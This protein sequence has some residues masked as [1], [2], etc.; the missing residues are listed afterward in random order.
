MKDHEFL[1]LLNLYLDHEIS[2]A[3][4]A[5]LEAEVQGNATHRGT[6]LEYCRMQKACTLLAKDF[7]D[8]PA[9][10]KVIA[11]EPRRSAWASGT[12]AVGGLA[13]AAACVALVLMKR[14]PESTDYAAPVSNQ[15]IASAPPAAPAPT[16]VVETPTEVQPA[17]VEKLPASAIAS[18]V[19]MPVRLR[20]G[21]IRPI[22][23]TTPLAQT[24]SNPDAAAMLAAL[25][26]N[27]QAQFEWMKAMQLAPMQGLSQQ[28]LRSDLGPSI[29]PASRTSTGGHPETI[30]ERTA[31]KFQK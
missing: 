10:K 22:F 15:A 21:D 30:V 31:F 13:V 25:Q 3:D 23:V 17:P 7:A 2:A 12:V 9:E 29:Q 19:T 1:E 28:D 16:A 11:F 5:R 24:V 8:Q 4:A 14:A 18:T 26:Q 6:Y 27:A 20:H